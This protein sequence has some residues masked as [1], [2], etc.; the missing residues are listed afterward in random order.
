MK[1]KRPKKDT[2][3]DVSASL[4]FVGNRGG[5]LVINDE[6]YSITKLEGECPMVR[7]SAGNLFSWERQSDDQIKEYIVNAFSVGD[8]AFE[9]TEF[10]EDESTGIFTVTVGIPAIDE[11]FAFT[12]WIENG[13]MVFDESILDELSRRS[14]QEC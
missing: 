14:E 3:D 13:K 12:F 5:L 9:V 1:S 10:K 6:E 4:T 2:K 8:G 11:S 7:K